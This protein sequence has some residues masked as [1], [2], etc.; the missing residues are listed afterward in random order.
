M[1]SQTMD[2]HCLLLSKVNAALHNPMALFT[3]HEAIYWVKSFRYHSQHRPLHPHGKLLNIRLIISRLNSWR[4]R[5]YISVS[6]WLINDLQACG[7]SN[8]DRKLSKL[9]YCVLMF[10]PIKGSSLPLFTNFP[11]SS[12]T[13]VPKNFH[14]TSIL[15]QSRPRSK[16]VLIHH[17]HPY[18][19]SIPSFLNLLYQYQSFKMQPKRM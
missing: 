7:R 16:I 14:R 19:T 1:A 3:P 17:F 13:L 10:E 2:N 5:K 18:Q 4:L 12:I 9:I 6:T 15:R 8:L 11:L